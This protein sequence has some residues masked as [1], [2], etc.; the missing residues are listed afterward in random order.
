MKK[1]Q[2]LLEF[3]STCPRTPVVGRNKAQKAPDISHNNLESKLHI[4]VL[5]G[6]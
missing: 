1:I 3:S 2:Y 5:P 6:L 4:D